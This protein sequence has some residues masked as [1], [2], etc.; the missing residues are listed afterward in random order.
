MIQTSNNELSIYSGELTKERFV[1]ET[2]KI[3]QAFPKMPIETFNLLKDRFK[4]NGFTDERLQ[5]SVNNVIDTYEGWDKIPNIANFI[6][7]DKKVKTYIWSES[8]EIGQQYLVAIDV[9]EDKPK[10]VM[11]EDQKKYKLKLWGEK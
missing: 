11:K 2:G 5:D 7:W 3:L 8:I 1:K 4:E 9:G 10:W 6:Q